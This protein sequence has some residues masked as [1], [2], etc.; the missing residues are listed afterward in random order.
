MRRIASVAALLLVAACSLALGVTAVAHAAEPTTSVHVV[1]YA[2]DGTTVLAEATLDYR[3]ME[4][5]LPVCG[6]GVTHYYHQGPVFEG[7]KW[8]PEET[9]NL[10]DRGAVKGTDVKDV[11][12]QVGGMSPGDEVM[13][14]AVDGYQV[15]FAYATVCEPPERQGPLVLCWYNGEDAGGGEHQGDGYPPSYVVAMRSV[16]MARTANAEGKFVFGNWDM[17]ECL[18]EEAQHF[19]G[20]LYPSTNGLSGKWIDE[21][22]VYSGEAPPDSTPAANPTPAAT[23]TPAPQAASDADATAQ[24]SRTLWLVVIGAGAAVLAAVL[25]TLS[26]RRR[27]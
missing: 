15:T 17:H 25:L 16:F 23:P 27:R 13:L 10:K 26:L 22:L 1:R 11:C 20:E 8:D 14:C 3:W 24:S 21:I 6:D 9:A 4:A 7:D 18:P 2:S 5:N 19:Y 12:E